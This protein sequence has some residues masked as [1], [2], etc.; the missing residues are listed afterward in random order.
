M[1]KLPI[2]SGTVEKIVVPVVAGLYGIVAEEVISG[3][4]KTT[5]DVVEATVWNAL[6]DNIPTKYFGPLGRRKQLLIY[7][8]YIVKLW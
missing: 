6:W 5:G 8:D 4:P 1:I 2:T 3:E 7:Y